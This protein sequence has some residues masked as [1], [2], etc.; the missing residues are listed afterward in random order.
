[1]RQ[2]QKTDLIFFFE[3]SDAR[4]FVARVSLLYDTFQSSVEDDDILLNYYETFYGLDE[5][6]GNEDTIKRVGRALRQF[7]KDKYKRKIEKK[8]MK[9][10]RC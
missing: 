8:E 10:W 4:T 9:D 5:R 3:V 6:I 1:M 7:H 2:R